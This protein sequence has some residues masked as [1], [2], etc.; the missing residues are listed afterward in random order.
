MKISIAIPTLNRAQLLDR[1][2]RSAL[3]QCYDDVEIIASDNGSIDDTKNTLSK[4]AGRIKAFIHTSTMSAAR[5]SEFICKQAT[6][7]LLLPLS[8]DDWLEPDFCA[9]IARLF[10]ENPDISFGY[11]GCI[12]HYDD[13]KVPSLVGPRIEDGLDFLLAYF[14]GHREVCWCACVVPRKLFLEIPP[15]PDNRIIGDMYFWTKLAFRGPVGCVPRPLSNYTALRSDGDNMSRLTSART[16]GEEVR[17]LAHETIQS[18]RISGANQTF[19][20]E[21]DKETKRYVARSTANQFV[22]NKIKGSG[23]MDLLRNLPGCIRLLAHSTQALLRVFAAIALP[24][25]VLRILVLEQAARLGKRRASHATK[26]PA[27][28]AS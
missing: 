5:H 24:R 11:T 1:A 10:S 18:A 9:E 15:L 3:A 25:Q 12:N 28:S 23:T 16:W 13:R 26:A 8:D 19:L 2:I 6:G 20:D 7:D 17:I 21:M 4:Y 27:V 22:W 14:S